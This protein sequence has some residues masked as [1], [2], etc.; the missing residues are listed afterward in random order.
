[1]KSKKSIHEGTGELNAS[2]Y[3]FIILIVV[4]SL[5]IY[6]NS[7]KNGFTFDDHDMIERNV[8]IRSLSP[9]NIGEIFSSSWWWGGA[10]QRSDEYRPLTVLSFAVYYKIADLHPWFYH[11]INILLNATVSVL[12]FLVI[13]TLTHKPVLACATA[14]I[15]AVHPVHTEAVNN[16]VG[17]AELLSAFFFLLSLLLFLYGISASHRRRW[18]LV[19]L[20]YTAYLLG[21]L[22][23][24]T[25]ITM[26]VIAVTA[27][28][29]FIYRKAEG[30]K[31]DKGK[32]GDP[33]SISDFIID[34]WKYYIG[35]AVALGI[36]FLLRIHALGGLVSPT[37][38]TTYLDNVLIL[39]HSQGDFVA[40]YATVLKIVGIYM[41]L[42]IF[43]STLSA[44]YSYDAVP[45][46]T[47]PLS[48]GVLLTIGALVAL[49]LYAAFH[50]RRKDVIPLFG[51][52]FFLIVFVP[53]SNVFTLIGITM[54]ER[55]VYLPSLGF[56]LLVS[57][58]LWKYTGT[59]KPVFIAVLTV[60]VLLYSLRT[61]VRNRDW[62]D[63][64]T[65]YKA[66]VEATPRC[67]RAH[68][69]LANHYKARGDLEQ[70]MYHYQRSWEI[71]PNYGAP[72]GGI[73]EILA[74]KHDFEE[75]EK[76]FRQVIQ[77]E[78]RYH[79]AHFNLALLL[80]K[81][82]RYEEAAQE[83]QKTIQLLPTEAGPYHNLALIMD[84]VGNYKEAEKFLR[85]AISLNPELYVTR[86]KLGDVLIKQHR[87]EEARKELER[88]VALQP[89]RPNAY[90]YLGKMF[91]AKENQENALKNLNKALELDPH[92]A[93][94][95]YEL[96]KVYLV[97][98]RDA[99]KAMYH[100][101]RVLELNP[102]HPQKEKVQQTLQKLN[103]SM[104]SLD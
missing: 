9:K 27:H 29:F 96:G 30:K 84:K 4:I 18:L 95:H 72:L 71:A 61:I 31:G 59:K 41:W 50:F 6:M 48:P 38:E 82:G 26:P 87:F 58:I 19:M 99:Q 78:D 83:Y 35:F 102:D 91:A 104:D 7:L 73:G 68:F 97:L 21:M 47:S 10:R 8:L 55:L 88:A 54:G 2:L 15:F 100:L 24:E 42:M 22:S 3:C 12:A 93:E 11:L 69:N 92:N 36:Y 77:M 75:A 49:I 67:S 14:L 60:L 74:M 37:M 76:I 98:L 20:S 62:R 101:R 57:H 28:W 64:M 32:K 46:V 86:V 94:V 80:D 63:D 52:L 51:L 66:T 103:E 25:A 13:Q 40:L 5:A 33:K 53:V 85:Q 16:I 43:P 90:Y 89:Q 23:K 65:L 70:A 1:M 45:L 17:E 81:M 44:D 56:F 39:A 79:P 34:T